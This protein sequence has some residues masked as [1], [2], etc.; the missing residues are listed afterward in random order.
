MANTRTS[1]L[2]TNARSSIL[3]D[4]A[5]AQNQD[6]PQRPIQNKDANKPVTAEQLQQAGAVNSNQGIDR[7]NPTAVQSAREPLS[8]PQGN[9]QQQAPASPEQDRIM[10][11]TRATAG[12]L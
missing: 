2:K 8:M 6:I 12:L 9:D 11:M 7:N 10:N 3:N 4:V 5:P 1:L